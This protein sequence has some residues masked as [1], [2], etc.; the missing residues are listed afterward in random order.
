MTAAQPLYL[1]PPDR[2]LFGWLHRPAQAK[3]RN[4]GIVFCNPFGYE[5]VCSHRSIRQFAMEAAQAGIAALRFDYDGTGDS[6][7]DDLEPQRVQAW[8]QSTRHAA[9]ALLKHAGVDRVAFVGIRLGAAI[10]TLAAEGRPD[11]ESIVAIAPTVNLNAYVRELRMLQLAMD[12]RRAVVRE[13]ISGVVEACGFLLSEE[14]RTHM[15]SVDLSRATAAPAPRV[16]IFDRA[17]LPGNDDW[18]DQL[19]GRGAQVERV[20][21]GNAAQNIQDTV[22]SHIADETIQKTLHW[23]MTSS[24]A[25]ARHCEGVTAP[26]RGQMSSAVEESA[27]H[28]GPSSNLFGIVSAPAV[29]ARGGAPVKAIML[30]NSGG[31]HHIGPNRLYVTLAR[32]WAALG[33]VVLR[34]DLAGLGDSAA[35]SGEPANVIY[36]RRALEDVREGIEYLKREWGATEVHA[37]GICSG[38]YHAFKA[39]VARQPL[40]GVILINPLTFFWKESVSLEFPEYRVAADIMRYRTKLFS[41]S[42]WLRLLRGRVNLWAMSQVLGRR[43]FGVT[44]EWS[45][46]LARL[47]RIPISEDLAAELRR[48]IAAGVELKFIFAARDPGV[49]LL[50]TKGGSQA[51]KLCERGAMK[52]ETVAGADHTF[53]DRAAREQLIGLLAERLDRPAA[54]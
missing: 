11:I 51:R 34:M 38:A 35:H 9:D 8:V 14:T 21:I 39:A 10:A 49:E 25:M 54:S 37:L 27:V 3:A 2:A 47:L 4:T 22:E 53:T 1:G 19:R 50:R 43:A 5:S 44:A 26:S 36:A 52:V 16:L 40:A 41:P 32:R 13:N 18:A 17:G 46:A 28:F 45:H 24:S 29:R 12:A 15:R 23:L 20:T 7:G 33:H 31:V 48:V 6:A 30:L 42:S